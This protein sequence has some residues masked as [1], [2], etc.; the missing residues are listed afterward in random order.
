MKQTWFETW[1][2]TPYYHQLYCDR[3]EQEA[4]DFI[5]NLV[6][7]LGLKKGE[8]LLDMGCGKGRHAKIFHDFGLTVT[9][10][11]LS[12]KRDRKSVV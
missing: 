4:A 11:D 1:F 10:V 12:A 2:D 6:S 7:F 5:S 8:K 9:G 3:N